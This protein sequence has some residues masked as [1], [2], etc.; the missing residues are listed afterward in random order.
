[1]I[2]VIDD[3]PIFRRDICLHLCQ[4]MMP[5]HGC[6][7]SA[8]LKL[9][10]ES[11]FPV[12]LFPRPYSSSLFAK[13]FKKGVLRYSAFAMLLFDWRKNDEILVSTSFSH[14]VKYP[15][16]ISSQRDYFCSEIAAIFENVLDII[17]STHIS[18]SERG[19]IFMEIGGKFIN[20][21]RNQMLIL[22][23]F[24][25]YPQQYLKFEDVKRFCSPMG[26]MTNISIYTHIHNI[27]KRVQSE[28]GENIINYTP[29]KGYDINRDL[30]GRRNNEEGEENESQEKQKITVIPDYD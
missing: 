6:S 24:A 18:I 20:F 10:S 8:A 12:A 9:F 13:L 30:L 4:S 2:L 21:T 17:Y 25:T 11:V 16:S 3:D 15:Y 23:L 5:A 26:K 19:N 28:I 22:D 27:N 1:M 14:V 7:Y 29:R